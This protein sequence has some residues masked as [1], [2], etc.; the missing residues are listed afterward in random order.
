MSLDRAKR[1]EDIVRACCTYAL[2]FSTAECA[3]LV[4][5]INP[6]SCTTLVGSPNSK[7]FES[8]L[9]IQVRF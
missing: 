5:K 4:R 2:A 6:F 9:E 3:F 7:P 1:R 8:L